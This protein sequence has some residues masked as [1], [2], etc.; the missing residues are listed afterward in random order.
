MLLNNK[1]ILGLCMLTFAAVFLCVCACMHGVC[2]LLKVAVSCRAV[3]HVFRE[4]TVKVQ[5]CSPPLSL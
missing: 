3:L 2:E 5:M 1:S 4:A